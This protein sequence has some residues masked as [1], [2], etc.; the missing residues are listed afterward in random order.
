[1]GTPVQKLPRAFLLD[2]SL[3]PVKNAPRPEPHN[4]KQSRLKSETG[5]D[6]WRAQDIEVCPTACSQFFSIAE[7]VILFLHCCPTITL[8]N[9]HGVCRQWNAIIGGSQELQE[10]LFLKHVDS[11]LSDRSGLNPV[12][13]RFF[14]P[15]LAST[16]G[17]PGEWCTYK[18]V[19]R[20]PWAS[21][22]PRLDAPARCAFSRREASWR[23]MLVCQPNMA[24]LD[25]WYRW[26]LASD[27]SMWHT[28]TTP[29]WRYFDPAKSKDPWHKSITL[30]MLWDIIEAR[31]KRQCAT[32]VY[33]F[34]GGMAI[35]A[36]P[37]ALPEE[38]TWQYWARGSSAD[39]SKNDLP[40]VKIVV[41]QTWR[42]D[43]LHMNLKFNFAQDRWEMA[44]DERLDKYPFRGRAYEIL[45]RDIG[46]DVL[47]RRF[48]HGYLD[49]NPRWSKSEG[50]QWVSLSDPAWS[51]QPFDEWE[52]VPWSRTS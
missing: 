25:L 42:L 12:L 19:A 46:F 23:R 10:R 51:V 43:P 22:G 7:L 52:R 8:V 34:H 24:R 13:G 9:A 15:I 26:R 5:R 6:C 39:I 3:V 2:G 38:R 48:G 50:F 20:L 45:E 14:A 29:E 36:D 11:D 33:W 37:E 32:R 31:L 27:P 35:R 30:G 16:G 18:D 40:R 49:G 17:G 41:S 47:E 44:K 1:M 4:L 28:R 21:D